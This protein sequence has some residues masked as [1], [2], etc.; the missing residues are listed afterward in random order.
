[1]ELHRT[2]PRLAHACEYVPAGVVATGEGRGWTG[3]GLRSGGRGPRSGGRR[4]GG[5]R[6]RSGGRGLRSGGHGLR[7][8]GRGLS[9]ASLP[10]WR[11]AWGGAPVQVTSKRP[12]E[13]VPSPCMTRA[14]W[15]DASWAPRPA[16]MDWTGSRAGTRFPRRKTDGDSCGVSGM[17]HQS[18]SE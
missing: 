6:L 17:R 12:P 9:E 8:G 2:S 1:M 3:R 13:P 11:S 16:S 7:S 18:I 4:L 10:V 5:R 15:T 14:I